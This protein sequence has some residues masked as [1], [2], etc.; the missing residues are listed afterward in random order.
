MNSSY[1]CFPCI[2]TGIGHI[3]TVERFHFTNSR[4]INFFTFQ[5]A[6]VIVIGGGL[7][8]VAFT[9]RDKFFNRQSLIA[10]QEMD[11]ENKKLGLKHLG[12]VRIAAIHAMLCVSN[13][14]E[15]G[16]QNSGPLK[17]MVGTVEGAVTAVVTPVYRKFEDIPDQL[18]VFFDAK[19][20]EAS[21]K[22]DEKAPPL[23]KRVV[24]QAHALLWVASEKA[25]KVVNEGRKAGPR[26]AM[27]CAAA[28]TK[29]I[30][31]NTSVNI[32]VKLDKYSTVHSVAKMT[33]PTATHLSE[34]YNLVVKDMSQKG[35]RVFR[36]LPEIPI[37]E[38]AKVVKQCEGKKDEAKKGAGK[39][40]GA[41]KKGAKK[42]GAKKDGAKK[43][44]KH[45]SDSDSD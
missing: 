19:V 45:K 3:I 40:S 44:G 5:S 15:Y 2:S 23:A 20:D 32:W 1:V 34:K 39:K 30:I 10:T 6:L 29:E 16:K 14:Y 24:S 38:I 31:L 8:C 21:H 4:S 26:A 18:L 42:D 37:D 11:T 17:S 41:K 13:L 43:E 7:T 12:F 28:E 9:L 27:Y 25:Q 35:Y 36:Y 22:F 33:V